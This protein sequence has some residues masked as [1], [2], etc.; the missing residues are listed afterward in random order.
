MVR[1]STRAQEVSLAVANDAA[2]VRVQFVA[3]FGVDHRLAILRAEHDVIQ[4][5]RVGLC[6]GVPRR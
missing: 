1:D 4:Q 2:D 3:P 6:H 5:L